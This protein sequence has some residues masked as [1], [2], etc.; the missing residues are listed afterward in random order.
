MII[1]STPVLALVL[2]ATVALPAWGAELLIPIAQVD[3]VGSV[4]S[5]GTLRASDGPQGLVLTPALSGLPPGPHGIHLHQ[6]PSCAAAVGKD[7]QMGAALA[8]GGHFDPEATGVHRGPDHAGHR[9]DLPRLEV[10][11]DG[12]ATLPLVAPRLHLSD[13]P[14]H[15]IV[16]HAGGDT[17]ADQPQPLGGGGLRIACGVIPSLP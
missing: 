1:R 8:A 5:L 17:Y 7:G 14:G 15:S 4:G 9:G 6:F 11:A 2:A 12:T 10:A 16:I 13:L 3:A